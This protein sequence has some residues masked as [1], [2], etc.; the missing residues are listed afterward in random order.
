[1]SNLQQRLIV[2]I[3]GAAG[4]I[5]GICLNQWSYFALFF[6]ICFFSLREFHNLINSVGI[7]TNKVFGIFLGLL[8]F[9]ITFLV[10]IGY[11]SSSVYLIFFALVFVL[12]LIELFQIHDKPFERTAFSFLAIVYTALPYALLN[13]AVLKSGQYNF[14]ILLGI[15][16][17]LWANDTG[18]Y[19]GGRFLGKHK[20]YERISPKKTW[21]GSISG[22]LL[23]LIISGILSYFF[24][25]FSP[26]IWVGLSLIIIVA[27]SMGDLVESQLKRSLSIKDSGSSIPGH[28]GFLDRFDGLIVSIPFIV[29]YLEVV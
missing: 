7:Q 16:L 20:L 21:E 18:G 5:T 28:G 3:A 15:L 14:Q 10:T 25:D 22:A 6:I 8:L 27:G 4:I 2:G 1:M 13:Y 26:V 29:L 24:H 23:S 12:F 9:T 19:F 17:L 11:L